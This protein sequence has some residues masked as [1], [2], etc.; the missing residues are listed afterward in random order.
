MQDDVSENFQSL[1]VKGGGN[2]IK[3]KQKKYSSPPKNIRVDVEKKGDNN[4][5]INI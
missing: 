4:Y 1:K 2:S 3:N 5:I